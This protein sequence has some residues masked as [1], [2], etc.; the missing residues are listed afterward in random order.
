MTTRDDAPGW[1]PG[2]GEMARLI[3]A[4]D[5]AA[6]PLG[7]VE[8][9]PRSLR[10][11]VDLLLPAGFPMAALWGPDLV[12]VYNDGFRR[13]MGHEHPEGLGRPAREGWPIDAPLQARV[14]AGESV[15]LEE[16]RLPL[17]G[18]DEG[19]AAWFT[20]SCSPLRD[21]GGAVAGV[22]VTAME[23]SGR[24]RAEEALRAGEARH[25]AFVTACS[26]V[27]YRMGPDWA[28]MR[29]LDG[30][31]LLAD[32]PEPD[33][34][35]LE[36]HVAPEDRPLVR[37][38]I[39]EAIGARAPFDL[40]HRV[41]RADGRLGWV[42]SRAVPVPDERGGIA[43]WLG[44]ARDVTARREAEDRL[45]RSEA[46]LR[47]V[48]D[49]MDEAFG[50]MD[51]DFRILAL[52]DAALRLEPMPLEEILGRSHWEVHPGSEGSE[53]GRLLRRAQAERSPVSLE[54]PCTSQDGSARWLEMRAFPMPEGLAVFWRDITGRKEAEAR[55]RE[56]EA[57]YRTLFESM[58]EGFYLAEAILDGEGRC[59]D[60]LYHDENP[61]AVRITG[62]S[63][64]GRRLSGLGAHEP[65][66]LEILGRTA[67]T[68][69]AQ[70]L[71]GF[72]G[73]DGILYDLHVFR[74]TDAK[75]TEVAV[76]L[77]DVTARRRAE[78]ALRGNAARQAFLLR[79]GDSLRAETGVDRLIEVAARLLGE[80]LGASRVLFA[81]LDEARGVADIFNGWSADGVEPFPTVMRLEDCEGPILDDLRAGRTVR[82]ED[83]RD[84][85][86]ARPDLAAIAAVGVAALLSVPLVAGGRLVVN[87]SVHQHAPRRWTDGEVELA[88]EVAERLWADLVR[89]RAEAALR[90]IEAR[91]RV[92]VSAIADVF[93][94]T[95]LARG[96]LDYLSP[97][98]ETVWGRPAAELLA[99]LGRFD[100]TLHPD[101]REAFRAGLARQARGE[102]VTIEYRIRRPDGEERWILDRSFPVPG[103]GTTRAAGMASDITARK[104]AEAALRAGEERFRAIVETATDYAILTIDAEGRIETWSPG[105]RAVFGWTAEEVAG[106]PVDITFTPEDR[107]RG[108]PAKERRVA[109]ATGEAPDVRWHRRRDG[110]RVF[111]EGMVRP[112]LGP[113]GAVAGF[114]KVGQ[115]VTARRATEA[116][117]QE[118]EARF[119][120]FGDASADVLW[121]RDAGT[122]AF[123]YVSPAFEEIYGARI[124]HVL[125]GNHVRRWAEL[126]LPE[127]RE[128]ALAAIRRVREGEH[129]LHSFRIR[130]ADGQVRWIRDTDFPLHDGSGRV[131]RIAG[132]GHDATEEVELQDRLRVLVAE[133]Q[134]RSR[135]LVT[136]VRAVT[137]R[138]LATSATLDEFRT[139]IRDRLGALGRVNSLL[140]RL[141]EGDR[142]AFDELLGAELTAHG[143]LDEAG[144]GPQVA[145]RGPKGIRLRSATVQTFA[146]ALHELTTNALKHGA[147]SR[148]EGHLAVTWNLL[149]GHGEDRRLRVDWRETGVAAGPRDA[150]PGGGPPERRGY[151]REL[152]ERALPYQLKAETDYRIT[153]EGVRCTIVVPVSSTL[154]L[155]FS[156]HGGEEG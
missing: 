45:R 151:G 40:E 86:P 116:A 31:G 50:L 78:E 100:D 3:R 71:E 21:E 81:E 36:R 82:V 134:H 4:R 58:D 15:T 7:P 118:S 44:A 115:D 143:V 23:V 56:S 76:V 5:W 69:E 62:R 88:R 91:F 129:V 13:I 17:D 1:P 156:S 48:L 70:R 122:L 102:P 66:W 123:E 49:G 80:H 67:R 20:L 101:D 84:P 42:H 18:S 63:R 11:T 77:H 117:L 35:W 37:A 154:D 27:A 131:Q 93:Y 140:S 108:E 74:P 90:E 106:R 14:R 33:P 55:L 41:R 147:L 112:L 145:L 99:D 34:D 124:E 64:K 60:L 103:H 6:T 10:A 138:T 94:I 8:G 120:Q 127:D 105:A 109:R 2:E 9:W 32:A 97:S 104:A 114:L 73:P 111:I 89:A 132:I 83:A 24:V 119:R 126:I 61:A 25:R 136:V 153:P 43:E 150:A 95:D 110:T 135:N 52:N 113:D 16:A 53:V 57:R 26:D 125:G 72:A 87:L 79:L 46:R 22:L 152:I 19:E 142:I 137:E 148:P 85:A 28:E 107:L 149:P 59:V 146:L 68:G 92:L 12:Q 141:D 96:R 47:G 139:R 29:E 155:A 30:R 54:H 39:A 38:A 65:H 121:I 51:Q 75:G 98:Y 130:R 144:H 128:R 133:L